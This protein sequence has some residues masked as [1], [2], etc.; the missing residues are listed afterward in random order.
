MKEDMLSRGQWGALLWVAALAPTAE[1]LPGTALETA[2]RGGWLSPLAAIIFLLPLLL[3]AGRGEGAFRRESVWRTPALILCAVWMELLLILRLALCARRMLWA[4]ER[5]GAVWYF[6]LTL[7]A[8]ALWMGQGALG[9]LGRAGQIFLVL[10]LGAAGLVLGLSVPQVRADRLLPLWTRDVLPVLRS[11]LSTA[12][13]LCWAL[14][15]LLLLP[16]RSRTGKTCLLWGAGGCVLLTLAQIIIIGNLGV[17]LSA[18]S[19]SAFFALTKSVGVEGA[20]QRVES[21]VSALWM[22]S[23]LTA[24]V[25][26]SHAI[27]LIWNGRVFHVKRE[28]VSSFALLA[29]T[30]AALWMLRWG[31]P[32]EMWNREWVWLGNL[33][34]CAAAVIAGSKGETMVKKPKS[35]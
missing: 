25:V 19:Q 17:G 1:L 5:D 34:A 16:S 4:G 10:L 6:L 30:G 21:V 15:P 22:L 9:T 7:S 2:G 14:L 35:R 20:F 23:D 33:V 24:C 18:R 27:G 26:L 12:G 32:V 28:T 13:H 11:S 29:G 31:A 8:L 3:A